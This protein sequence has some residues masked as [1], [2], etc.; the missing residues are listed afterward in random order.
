MN[1]DQR[2]KR[3]SARVVRVFALAALSLLMAFSTMPSAAFAQDGNRTVWVSRTGTKYH[4]VKTCSDM[5]SPIEMTLS[6]AIA[7]GKK[8]CSNCVHDTSGGS[9]GSSGSAGS[10]AASDARIDPFTDVYASTAHSDDISWLYASGITTGW[11]AGNG[12]TAFCP[13]DTVKRCDMAAFLYRLAGSPAYE[14]PSTSPF[15]DVETTTSHYKEICWLSESGIS[16]G[17][18]ESDGTRTFRPF[19]NAVRADVSAFL[20]RLASYLGG[21]VYGMAVNP[22]SDVSTSTPHR[23]EI[24]WMVSSE[25]STGWKMDDGSREF[26]PFAPIVRA[27]MAAFLHRLHNWCS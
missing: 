23:D 1:I 6:A 27:D 8:P 24:L 12:L 16:T 26:R 20:K 9:S 25:I 13:Y 10:G 14:A 2:A 19:S 17:W 5:V 21:D 11:P 22:F 4:Y 3:S 15:T 7:A 18:V